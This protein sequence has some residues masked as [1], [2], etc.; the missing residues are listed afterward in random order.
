MAGETYESPLAGRYAG[1]AMKGLWSPL[2][3]ART[4]RRLWL[5]LAEAQS[6][7]GLAVEE[8]QLETL[9]RHL[10]DVDLA[11][12]RRRE[13]ELRHDVM[14]HLASF[15]ALCPEAKP[16]LHW[17]AT[18]A[19][20]QDNADLILMREGLLLVR[21]GLVNCLDALARFAR[22]WRELPTLAYTHFQ[23][24]Q[25]TTVGKRA[26]LWTQDFL[27]DLLDL[28]YLLETLPFRGVKGTTGTQA[29][30]LTLFQGDHERVRRLDVLVTRK[31]GFP[32]PVAV[33]GQTITR[34][35]DARVAGVL[36]G[37]AQ[38][39]AK[40]GNDLRLLQHLGEVE[41]PFEAHQVG[42]SAMPYKRNPMRAERICAL[43]RF[44]LGAAANPAYTA[45]TQWLERTLDD[46][47]NRR[48]ALPELFLAADGI[49]QLVLDVA[50]GLVVHP[51][52]VA[53]NLRRELP[54]L[55]TETILMEAVRAGGDR[56]ELHEKL[57]VHA[58]AAADRLKGGGTQ[59][60][61]FARLRSDPAFGVVEAL[62]TDEVDPQRFVGRAPEQVDEF[63]AAQVDPVLKERAD[64]IGDAPEVVV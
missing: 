55:A 1:A 10:D 57:R 13:R 32:R 42:S 63:L 29:S 18:S 21:R 49:L 9:R 58:R 43:A 11:D 54:F 45:A 33:S 15:G 3:I 6:E 4:W 37:L 25:P 60:D 5:W 44:V 20:V 14:A 36:A 34:K 16:I 50:R 48:L 8:R 47:A 19:F 7:L 30:F 23:A 64:L 28:E 12:I 38:S 40:L 22:E 39:A 26:T 41:E 51:P 61:L 59:N 2:Q 52:V 53:R 17:G 35:Q 62:L 27:T 24:A 46:S 31:A 56:Q